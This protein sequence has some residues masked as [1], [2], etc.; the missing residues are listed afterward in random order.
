MKAYC[1]E[2]QWPKENLYATCYI[3][4][5]L[6]YRYH[7]H[8]SEYEL[9]IVLWGRQEFC[10]GK[11]RCLMEE[12]DVILIDPNSGH[13]SFSVTENTRTLVLRFSALAFKPYL[14]KGCR[15]VFP[16]CLSNENNR[17]DQTFAKIRFYAA[18]VL[19]AASR[20]GPYS[21]LAEKSAMGMLLATFLQDCAPKSISRMP[22]QNESQQEL[23]RRLCDYIE[24]H[25]QEKLTLE[26]LARFSQYNRTYISTLFK[27]MVGINFHDYLMRIRMKHAIFDLTNNQKNLTEIAL[28]HGFSDLKSFNSR[29]REIFQYS[30]SEYRMRVPG[31]IACLNQ[32]RR[33]ISPFAPAVQ[34][35]L[36]KYTTL[37]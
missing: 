26:D 11:E 8:P 28:E 13:A 24:V 18:Q 35:K 36:R 17:T 21:E 3:N 30:P 16:E 23:M 19:D 27:N 10:R 12:D 7:W 4:E 9:Q 14:E 37:P 1:Y 20:K 6:N 31:D 22:D 34:E 32:T 29:F 15:F 33:L 25:Y 2:L 5:S